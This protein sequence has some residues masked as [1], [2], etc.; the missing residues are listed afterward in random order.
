MAEDKMRKYLDANKEFES[1]YSEVQKLGDT[2]SGVGD[3]LK[4]HPYKLSVSNANVQFPI[5]AM[6]EEEY[7]LDAKTWPSAKEIGEALATLH[8]K[9]IQVERIWDSLPQADK[10]AL[11]PPN[12]RG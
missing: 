5:E 12:I 3:I 4:K 11:K 1:A 10:D 2:I 9:R 8:T 6:G 7:T